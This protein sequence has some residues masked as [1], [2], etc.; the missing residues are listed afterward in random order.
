MEIEQIR[1]R[2]EDYINK[3]YPEMAKTYRIYAGVP[4][5]S[6]HLRVKMFGDLKEDYKRLITLRYPKIFS[7]KLAKEG[8]KHLDDEKVRGYLAAHFMKIMA[9]EILGKDTSRYE[10]DMRK[11]A[12]VAKK[13]PA[14]ED[15]KKF[16]NEF[17]IGDA[18]DKKLSFYVAI[19]DFPCNIYMNP[20]LPILKISKNK[21][22]QEALIKYCIIHEAVH[23]LNKQLNKEYF[24]EDDRTARH[25]KHVALDE[26]SANSFTQNIFKEYVGMIFEEKRFIKS[27]LP[28]E[29]QDSYFAS[30]GFSFFN[31]IIDRFGAKEAFKVL[32]R[33]ELVSM[34]EIRYPSTY[35]T[36]DKKDLRE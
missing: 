35:V 19:K 30:I 13:H 17:V 22:T 11:I 7:G 2:L 18:E 36:L 10:N 3:A 16:V 32:Q 28:K 6:P 33:P 27:S 24:E 15:F 9:S 23:L 31:D 34:R 26:G 4:I 12:A 5:E 8:M 21:E 25:G 14:F 20:E 29:R 1:A